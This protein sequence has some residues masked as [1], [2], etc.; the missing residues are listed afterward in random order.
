MLSRVNLIFEIQNNGILNYNYQYKLMKIIYEALTQYDQDMAQH[1]HSKGYK[2]DNKIFKLFNYTMLFKDAEFDKDG[3]VLTKNNIVKLVFTG[4]Q[5]I[6]NNV[7]KGF[8]KTQSF[9]I[10]GVDFR[11]SN[12]E[13]DKQIAFKKKM[14]YKVVSPIIESIYEEEIKYLTPFDNRFYEALSKNLYRKYE[15]IYGK[16][17]TGKLYFDI[18][19]VLTIKK[20]T[21]N[22]I[23]NGYHI[24]YGNFNIW[25]EA[26]S[27]MQKVAYYCGLGQNNSIGAGLLTYIT[28]RS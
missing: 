3:I 7:V 4:K 18:E 22:D 14:L 6:V 28:G 5:S 21:I 2:I 24:G 9:N 17:Y 15:L 23:K 8:I 26:D 10:D 16:K 20:K 19:N 13:N 12:M 25:V 11:L 1:L 27:T